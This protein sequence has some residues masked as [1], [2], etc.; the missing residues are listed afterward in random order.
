MGGATFP[1]YFKLKRNPE[2]PVDTIILNGAEC[3][4]YLTADHR[5]MVECPEA[6]VVGLQLAQHACGA[7][8]ALIAIE[9]NKPDAIEALRKASQGRSNVEVVVCT[10]KYPMG[11][12]RQ[13][14]PAVLNRVVPSAPKGLPLDVGVVVVNVSTA[15]GIARAVVR[16]QPFTHRVVTVT[17]LGVKKARQLPHADRHDPGV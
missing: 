4:P 10:T 3:E 8:R 6:I 9:E 7:E 13:L 17:G 1:T 2:Q 5:L 11:G 16:D 14:I 12:E 15:H